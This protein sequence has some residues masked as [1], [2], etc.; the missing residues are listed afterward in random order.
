M[1]VVSLT[2]GL[3]RTVH[4]HAFTSAR[5][6]HLATVHGVLLALIR[7]LRALSLKQRLTHSIADSS[8][9]LKVL[10]RMSSQ[11]RLTLL[12]VHLSNLRIRYLLL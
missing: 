8:H 3:R 6:L 4:G 9:L 7:L 5:I 10:A 1:I 12:L 11:L 2:Q